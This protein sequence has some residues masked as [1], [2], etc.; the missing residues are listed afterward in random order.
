MFLF[1][2]QQILASAH[3]YFPPLFI[4]WNPTPVNALKH[5]LEV[6]KLFQETR[7]LQTLCEFVRIFESVSVLFSPWWKNRFP[8]SF[9]DRTDV[10]G[11][12]YRLSN[13]SEST[14][15]MDTRISAPICTKYGLQKSVHTKL[16]D[17]TANIKFY[18][19][20]HIG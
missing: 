20:T 12:Q 8:S 16:M 9:H 4:A 5:G 14:S 18:N 11:G 10:L 17:R 1:L 13:G 6:A 2:F 15:T 7:T 3:L 19:N